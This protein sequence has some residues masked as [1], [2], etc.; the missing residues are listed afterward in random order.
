VQNKESINF[1]SIF[2]KIYCELE[3]T[4][5]PGEVASYIPELKN[6]DPDKF[7][8]HLITL[9]GRH[10]SFGN[11][12]EKF[13]IQSIAKVLALVLAY[14]LEDE[15]LWERVGVEPSGTPF[16]SLVQLEY[17]KG[18]PR[19]P[20]INAGALVLS[21]ILV[22]HF[23]DPKNQF[24]EFVRKVSGIPEID[25]SSRIA[26]SEKST[27]FTNAALVNLMKS[28]GNIRNEVDVVLDFYFNLCSIEMTCAELS[29]TFLFLADYGV[30]PFN[31]EKI[32][33]TSKSKRINAIMQLCGFYDEAGEFSFKVGLP[34][35][36][37]VGGGIIAIHPNRYSI[38]VWSPRLNKKGNSI[39]GMKFL[40]LFTTETEASIF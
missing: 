1:N 26:D 14:K 33:S 28:F 16:N 13:S 24:I 36:S 27:G 34:G 12:D 32:I 7:G 30:C 19:N 11:S 40:E 10:F 3:K 38:A 39:R 18:I 8:I 17:D 22:S 31:N 35:K 25:Y 5:D 37:G 21:D 29:K 2:S 4:D 9:D 23:D 6:V 20:L 15:K